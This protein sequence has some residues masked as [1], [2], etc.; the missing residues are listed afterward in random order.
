MS[1]KLIFDLSLFFFEKSSCIFTTFP[2]LL[3]GGA[4]AAATV[5]A[6]VVFP[7]GR[8]A[9]SDEILLFSIHLKSRDNAW[10]FAK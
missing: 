10:S 6:V 8:R 3:Y 7:T 9:D 2:H 4:A 1:V 5:A